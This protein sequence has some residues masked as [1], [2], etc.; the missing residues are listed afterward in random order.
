MQINKTGFVPGEHMIYNIC[1]ENNSEN[2]ISEISLEL[3]QV[4]EILTTYIYIN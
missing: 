3:R 1:V 4:N 2:D